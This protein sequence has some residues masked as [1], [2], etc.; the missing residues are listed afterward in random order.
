M[1]ASLGAIIPDLFSHLPSGQDVA[2]EDL[3]NVRG[4]DTLGPLN[5][6]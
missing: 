6:G 4:I 5:G 2:E 3:L 1:S